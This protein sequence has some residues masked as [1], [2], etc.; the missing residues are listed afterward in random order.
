MS[1]MGSGFVQVS[2]GDAAS[3]IYHTRSGLS[4]LVGAC[5]WLFRWKVTVS[6]FVLQQ[7]IWPKRDARFIRSYLKNRRISR[8]GTQGFSPLPKQQFDNS[9]GAQCLRQIA[10]ELGIRKIPRRRGYRLNGQCMSCPSAEAALYALTARLVGEDGRL[11]PELRGDLNNG[12]Y[13]VPVGF[14]QAARALGLDSRFYCSSRLTEWHYRQSDPLWKEIKQCYAMD[15]SS[16]SPPSLCG[17]ERL[18]VH[19]CD[20]SMINPGFVTTKRDHYIMQR[21]DGSCYDPSTGK[22]YVS[23]A[24]Y[25]D[26][27]KM[28]PSGIH[29]LI[30]NT[31]AYPKVLST[32]SSVQH[33]R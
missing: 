10:Y 20:Y 16:S 13:S 12:G 2:G 31:S 6:E 11:K 19:V 27:S 29:V 21:P 3:F 33:R 4:R 17:N 18:L 15:Y 28:K 8:A 1:I 14:R 22:N 5:Y 30:S 32:V 23:M 7:Y 25:S 9:C 24:A 26:A